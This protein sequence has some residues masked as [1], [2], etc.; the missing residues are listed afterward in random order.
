[1][2]RNHKACTEVKCIK[3]LYN[4]IIQSSFQYANVVRSPIYECNSRKLESVQRIFIKILLFKTDGVYLLQWYHNAVLCERTGNLSLEKRRVIVS[5]SFL[6]KVVHCDVDCHEIL[7]KVN[8]PSYNSRTVLLLKSNRARTNIQRKAPITKRCG[9]F[10]SFYVGQDSFSWSRGNLVKSAIHDF[11]G[12]VSLIEY[13]YRFFSF[14]HFILLFFQY[15]IFTL[16]CKWVEVLDKKAIIIIK[17]A[18]F[19]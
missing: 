1:M 6:F 14:L 5:L 10:K 8:S 12:N 2:V 16:S 13:N 9:N 17:F 7:Y 3:I 11:S 4:A 19:Y 15:F 18:F